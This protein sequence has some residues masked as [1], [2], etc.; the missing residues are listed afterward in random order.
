M[1]NFNVDNTMTPSVSIYKLQLS[2][3]LFPDS[4]VKDLP[5][6]LTAQTVFFYM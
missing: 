6:E 4:K 3:T 2:S 1:K 5:F